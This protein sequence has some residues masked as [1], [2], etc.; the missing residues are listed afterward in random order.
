ML[1]TEH[2]RV[3]A[4]ADS[5]VSAKVLSIDQTFFVFY[6]IYFILLVTIAI[7]EVCSE[8]V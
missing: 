6:F 1:F 2:I 8:R 3:T 7:M 4:L 5:T